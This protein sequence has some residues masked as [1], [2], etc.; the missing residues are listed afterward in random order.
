MRTTSRA[1]Q[2]NICL[3][4]LLLLNAC[5]QITIS[6]CFELL[7]F[8]YVVVIQFHLCVKWKKLMLWLLVTVKQQFCDFNAVA[9]WRGTTASPYIF[10]CQRIC[11]WKFVHFGGI[12]GQNSNF[13]CPYLLCLKFAAVCWK[14]TTSWPQFFN[15]QPLWFVT[16]LHS[17]I[18]LRHCN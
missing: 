5:S 7:A 10:V 1:R 3:M 13:E 4:E 9:S 16:L 14:I 8:G 15:T 2:K 17:D 12:L 6:I 11:G 18:I